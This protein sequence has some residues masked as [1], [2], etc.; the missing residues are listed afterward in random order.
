MC[1]KSYFEDLPPENTSGVR[2]IFRRR[3]ENILEGV[4]NVIIYRSEF[5]MFFLKNIV[6]YKIEIITFFGIKSNY[7]AYSI[8]NIY[9]ACNIR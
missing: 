3:F 2:Q 1:T 8:S 7:G 5:Y 6:Q 9:S 4:G